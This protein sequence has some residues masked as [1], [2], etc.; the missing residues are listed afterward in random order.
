MVQRVKSFLEE[1]R[2]NQR[3]LA[4]SI[5]VNQGQLSAYLHHKYAGDVQGIQKLHIPRRPRQD[6]RYEEAEEKRMQEI[7]AQRR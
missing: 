4:D 1:H 3:W 6:G 7:D 2:K 5:G